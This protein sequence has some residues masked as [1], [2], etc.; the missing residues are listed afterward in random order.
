MEKS[1]IPILGIVVPCYNEEEVILDTSTT[2]SDILETLSK[3]GKI[4]FKSFM[5]FVDDGSSD[6]T[7]SAIEGLQK[8]SKNIRAIKL[9][10]NY[11]H[12]NALLSGITTFGEHADVLI[13]IDA[14]LQDDVKAIGEMIEKYREGNEIV[15][16]V[17]NKR[18]HDSWF[19]KNS[20]LVF[21]KM[22]SLLGVNIVYNHADF[23]LTSK[24]VLEALREYKEENLF[25]RGIFPGMGFRSAEVYYNRD[26]RKAGHSKYPF[27]KMLGF[28]WEGVTSF[29]IK[30]LRLVTVM[31]FVVFGASVVLGAYVVFS[32][33]FLQVVH[34]WASTVLPIYAL[35]GIQLLALGIIGEYLGK[36]YQ[37]VKRRPR[38]LI[39]KQL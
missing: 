3:Q 36:I 38:Y 4:S 7:W 11:G 19:K 28:A 37:E 29:S 31:G 30:P 1:T 17:R 5:G 10:R 35:G 22:M 6:K 25:L 24:R 18:D 27:I 2:L 33:Y 21:Y 12:Q 14:D 32:A 15:Y 13:S 20:A 23:R 8:K 34:G 9:A 26:A 39:E 16:G